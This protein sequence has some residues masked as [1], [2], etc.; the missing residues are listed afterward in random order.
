MKATKQAPWDAGA[1]ASRVHRTE[2]HNLHSFTFTTSLKVPLLKTCK[3][4][5]TSGKGGLVNV[6]IPSDLNPTKTH[7]HDTRLTEQQQ[8][9]LPRSLLSIL[10]QVFVD[11]LGS[12]GGHLV[13]RAHRAPHDR[14]VR[15]ANS[16]LS[17]NTRRIATL[18]SV[19]PAPAQNRRTIK[20]TDVIQMR[21]KKHDLKGSS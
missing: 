16:H 8:L 18:G 1:F 11:H 20:T 15:T 19:G 9:H 7:T 6:N 10:S 13:F 17:N 5:S 3:R 12:L 21:N 4:N 2:A 14:T